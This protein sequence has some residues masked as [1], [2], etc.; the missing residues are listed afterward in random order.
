MGR[1]SLTM[2]R[3]VDDDSLMPTFVKDQRAGTIDSRES[4]KKGLIPG[5][6]GMNAVRTLNPRRARVA[7]GCLKPQIA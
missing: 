3:R 2:T 4:I 7:F 1:K 5:N 6:C